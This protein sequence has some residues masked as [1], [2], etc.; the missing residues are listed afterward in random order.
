MA[1]GQNARGPGTDSRLRAPV[2]TN[3]ARHDDVHL[4]RGG[5]LLEFCPVESFASPNQLNR[6][7]KSTVNLVQFT[8]PHLF[9]SPEGRLRGVPTLPA[10]R[11]TLAAAVDDIA[12][13]HAVLA[14]GD[15]VNDDAGGYV[16]FRREFAA[17]GKPVLCIPGNH[18]DVAAMRT[19]LAAAPFQLGGTW[20]AGAWRVILLDSTV[21][22]R[23]GGAL[24]EAELRFLD[25]ALR[26]APGRH[27]LVCLHHHPVRMRSRWLDTV[28]LGNADAFFELL[29]RHDQV[30]AVLFGHVHQPLDETRDGIRMLATPSTCAQFKPRSNE[31][32]T[33]DAPPAW[34]TLAL[35]ADGTLTTGLHEVERDFAV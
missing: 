25:Q 12:A 29:G 20:D 34:R 7:T 28:G 27:S 3:L 6:L 13:C 1:A 26:D 33:D 21:A 2:A 5:Q 14:T 35:H 16:H 19:A 22:G 18:D 23:T 24:A 32:A 17:L 9:A 10:L 30:R 4:R 8:D 11:A 31:F 15:L